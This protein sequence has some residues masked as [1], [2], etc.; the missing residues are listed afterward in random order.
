MIEQ[1]GRNMSL[2]KKNPQR[3]LTQTMTGFYL[4]GTNMGEKIY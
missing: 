2:H 4:H 3:S 1:N